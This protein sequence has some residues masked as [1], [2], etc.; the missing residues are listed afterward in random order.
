METKTSSNTRLA[1]AILGGAAVGA[2]LGILFAPDKGS[3]TR[4]KIADTTRKAGE[5]VKH[6][7]K[8]IYES[9]TGG[10]ESMNERM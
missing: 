5:R 9:V 1:A 10:S 2:L 4:T 6:R 3:A 8:D 7:I